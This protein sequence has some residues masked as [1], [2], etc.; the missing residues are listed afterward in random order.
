[1]KN[2]ID[3]DSDIE[4]STDSVI[5]F[6]SR[7]RT[8]FEVADKFSVD[9]V[10][11]RVLIDSLEALNYDIFRCLDENHEELSFIAVPKTVGSKELSKIP[12]RAWSWTNNDAKQPYGTI[13]FPDNYKAQKIRIIPLDGIFYGDKSHDAQRFDSVIDRIQ[14]EDGTFCFINGD[15][16]SNVRNKD[17]DTK[18]ALV[19]KRSSDFMKKLLPIAHK[20]LWAQQ[21][22]LESQLL[23]SQGFDPLYYISSRFNIPYFTEPAYIDVWWNKNLFTI[24]SMH[25]YSSATQKGARLNAL[26]NSAFIHEWTHFLISGHVGDAMWNRT[27]KVCRDPLKGQLVPREEFHVILGNFKKYFGTYSACRGVLPPSMETIGLYIYPDGSHH[28]KTDP[29]K[30]VSREKP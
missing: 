6:L 22:C 26:R 11:A 27:I 5:D 12:K 24:W 15:V 30:E 13:K 23:D 29:G 18:E 17:K 7:S 3:F 2:D 25:G 20:I 14:N 1:M 16:I 8:L 21:G 4:V 10:E 9:V 28:V 19:L